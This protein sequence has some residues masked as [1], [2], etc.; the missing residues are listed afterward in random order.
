[1]MK[2]LRKPV[3]RVKLLVSVRLNVLE[4]AMQCPQQCKRLLDATASMLAIQHCSVLVLHAAVTAATAELPDLQ[5]STKQQPH[6][7]PESI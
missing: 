1:M 2:L 6:C 5:L 3:L 4:R 7:W